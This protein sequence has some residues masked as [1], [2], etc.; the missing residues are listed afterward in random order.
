MGTKLLLLEEAA[1]LIFLNAS[2]APNITGAQLLRDFSWLLAM[3]FTFAGIVCIWPIIWDLEERIPIQAWW[4]SSL[5]TAYFGLLIVTLD[6]ML[7]S[8]GYLS[9]VRG[10]LLPI[11]TVV[12]GLIFAFVIYGT[13]E[14]LIMGTTEEPAIKA[15]LTATEP[16][17]DEACAVC[18][19]GYTDAVALPCQHVF[20]RDCIGMALEKKSRCPVCNKRYK[21]SWRR[22]VFG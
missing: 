13:I 1:Y 2:S 15:V 11:T 18:M 10:Q 3:C 21:Q 6:W 16:G 4:M 20:C 22:R 5:G 7:V 12:G 8:S 9:R 19:G 17:N 14:G